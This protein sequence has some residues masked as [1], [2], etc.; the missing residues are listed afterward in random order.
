MKNPVEYI[1]DSLI[2]L[3]K[4]MKNVNMLKMFIKDKTNHT[5]ILEYFIERKFTLT[6][7]ATQKR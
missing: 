3:D 7:C 5:L 6:I 4:E 2:L 1:I